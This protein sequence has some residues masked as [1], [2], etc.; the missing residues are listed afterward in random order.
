[1]KIKFFTFRL[2]TKRRQR[3]PSQQYLAHKAAA[4]VWVKEHLWKLNK[5]YGFSYKNV[6]IKNQKTRWG[7]CSKNGNLNFNY[8]LILLPAELAEYVLTHELCHL[9]E[10][11][12]S[13]R[14]WKLV[15]RTMPDYKVRRK[16]LRSI[17]L[18]LQKRSD[19]PSLASSYLPV[20]SAI[21]R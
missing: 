15:E 16:R 20:I 4:L 8:R 1:M 7:S 14:F 9:K 12:H 11:N 3:R 21:Q 10:L 17:G 2:A 5:V 6:A 19:M 13:E 18:S